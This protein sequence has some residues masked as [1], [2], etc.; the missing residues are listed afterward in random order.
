MWIE[1]F[2]PN[3]VFHKDIVS[4]W[5]MNNARKCGYSVSTQC[6]D[7]RLMIPECYEG[8][9]YF[10]KKDKRKHNNTLAKNE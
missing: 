8:K 7:G 1:D 4:V 2:K 5:C 3:K 10:I 6:I 9:V